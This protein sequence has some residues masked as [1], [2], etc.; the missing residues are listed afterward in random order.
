MSI[1]H[2][3]GNPRNV[4]SNPHQFAVGECKSVQSIWIAPGCKLMKHGLT[5]MV[6]DRH[7]TDEEI[8]QLARN[9]G[10]SIAEFREW[11][12]PVRSILYVFS[13]RIIHFTD[14]KY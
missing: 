5:V 11:F 1:Q 10:L 13:G 4:R 12:L 2:W 9:D 8:E 7:L 14:K 3:R 6:D